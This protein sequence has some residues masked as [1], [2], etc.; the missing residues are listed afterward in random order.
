MELHRALPVVGGTAVGLGLMVWT[1]SVGGTIIAGTI[2]GSA[3]S[4]VSSLCLNVK[5]DYRRCERVR[6]RWAADERYR[7]YI[8]D[9]K[10]KAGETIPAY[11][12]KPAEK[13]SLL[14]ENCQDVLTYVG[15]GV[16]VALYWLV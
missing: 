7:V 11:K 6:L 9:L 14:S 16:F 4:V 12:L 5:E 15:L 1:G 3:A 13:P 10:R 2:L 8:N